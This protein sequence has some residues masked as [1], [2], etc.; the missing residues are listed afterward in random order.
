MVAVPN[1][2]DIVSAW[3]RGE[4]LRGVTPEQRRAIGLIAS[5]EATDA[6][7]ASAGAEFIRGVKAVLPG[8]IRSRAFKVETTEE[9]NVLRWKYSDD[10]PDRMG[11][12]IL[13]DGWEL[14]NYKKNGVVL[15]GH[16]FGFD[17]IADEP[18]GRSKKVWVEKSGTGMAL[19]GDILFAVD[20]SER[21]ARI[22]RLA[23]S[24]FVSAGSVG[25]RPK[26]IKFI[27]DEDERAR[28][29]LGRYGVVFEK[30]ELLEFSLCAVPANANA[31]QQSVKSGAIT[32]ADADELVARRTE[33][34]WEKHMRR[35]ARSFLDLGGVP[36]K[37]DTTSSVDSMGK[38]LESDT[39]QFLAPALEQ[40]AAGQQKLSTSI[41]Q[42]NA[43]LGELARAITDLGG[44]VSSPRSVHAQPQPAAPVVPTSRD[45]ALVAEALSILRT[46]KR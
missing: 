18:I 22:Y 30:Q 17:S 29:G 1:Y 44:C 31:L 38:P 10:S 13:Q 8:Q 26:S 9:E 3:A 35:K 46:M 11:D 15:W 41:D 27:D 25:F 21:G 24:G 34:D 32:E 45:A 4:E 19:F 39:T 33:R 14:E 16:A 7:L 6:E 37:Q 28:L 12:I 20:E 2:L 36:I 5:G 43:R 40:L 23:K 42:F